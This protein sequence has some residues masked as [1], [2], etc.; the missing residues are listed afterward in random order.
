VQ[1]TVTGR[2][3][4]FD[5]SDMPLKDGAFG[6]LPMTFADP[7]AKNFLSAIMDIAAIE[8]GN[9][10][11]RA[12]WQ[13]KQ[14]QNLLAHSAQRS[15]FWK[16]R[17]GTRRTKSVSLGDLPIQSRA[18]VIRQFETEGS[19]LQSS[20]ENRVHK[21]ATSG[22]TGEPVQFFITT[23][24]S[25]FNA[26][27]S[28]AQ[29][30][31]EGRDLS[32]NWTRIVLGRNS[33]PLGFEARKSA[34]WLEPLQ[35][36]VQTGINKHI[37]Y[38]NPDMDALCREMERDRIGY[39]VVNAR[40]VDIMLQHVE[41]EFFRH[42]GTEMVMFLAEA[43]D[44]AARKAVSSTGV[45]VRGSY[46][47]EEV[48]LIAVECESNPE[49]YHVATSNV[50]VEVVGDETM[51]FGEERIGRVVVT[52]LHSYAT[53]FIRYDMGDIATL[54]QS[55]PCGYEGPVLSNIYGRARSL[56]RHADGRVSLFLLRSKEMTARAKFKE[57]RIRQID[58]K[59]I[60]VEIGGRDSLAPQETEALIALVKLNA[61]DDFE[62]RVNAVA[63]IDWGPGTK[64][65]GFISEVL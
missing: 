46:S 38:L 54:G 27:R 53:P 51:Q 28:A 25:K 8:T 61:G 35:K 60:I 39:L 47:S 41:P 24:N 2:A 5:F 23:E 44:P 7:M 19:L 17:I 29:F 3:M 12:Y 10:V 45:P 62:V 49:T 59:T 55:C 57:Y 26:A 13:Q 4:R 36:L 14:L 43:M 58:L 52:H 1:A 30:F 32:L 37:V 15:A 63:E 6:E 11:A 48:G 40:F 9:P 34:T 65:L 56:V 50:V 22:S 16:K 21:H 42:V 33:N 64:R 18:D 20:R 31:M